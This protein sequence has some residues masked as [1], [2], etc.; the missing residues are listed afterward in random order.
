MIDR[1]ADLIVRGIA[2]PSLSGEAA[3]VTYHIVMLC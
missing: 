2:D 1:E 3:A